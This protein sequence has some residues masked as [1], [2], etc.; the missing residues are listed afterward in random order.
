MAA[1][2]DPRH[3]QA[4]HESMHHFVASSPWKDE[5]VLAVARDYALCALER[6]APVGAWV[7]DDTGMPKKGTH[8]VGVARQYCGNLGKTDN[9]QVAVSVT[10]AN[11]TMSVPCAYR[12]YLT[13]EWS[14]D[15][16]RRE[17]AGVPKEVKFQ[18]KWQIAL[19]QITE[20]LSVDLPRAPVLADAGY[21]DTTPFRDGITHLGLSYAVCVKGETTV[22]PPGTSPLPP[23]TWKGQGRPPTLLR[24]NA[25]HRPVAIKVLV[26]KIPRRQW[27]SVH[28]REGTR[29]AMRSRFAALRVI[30]AH[31]DQY[32]RRP[33]PAEWLLAEWPENE[34]KPTKFWLSTVPENTSLEEIVSLVMLRWR[35]ERDYEELKSEI[36]LDQYEG[37]NWRGFHHHG[38]LCI[39][40][41]CFLAAERARLSPPQPLAFLRPARLPKGFKPRGS[42]A[43]V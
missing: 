25:S 34:P 11:Q 31:R 12:L 24:R 6:H 10:L 19:D 32:R 35:I 26:E 27:K 42:P 39:A 36:G 38:V 8:S 33:R 16:A 21:G 41:Y 14:G 2:I 4:R 29:G 28:W 37:R 13:E 20:L 9:C 17:A 7:V 40:A 30:P 3:T 5:D 22:W 43:S 18:T 1:R 23:P 15:K